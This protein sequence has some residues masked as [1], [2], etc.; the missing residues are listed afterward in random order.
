MR[1]NIK[2][3]IKSAAKTQLTFL[4]A[5]LALVMSSSAFADSAMSSAA[6]PL[7]AQTD[8]QALLKRIEELERKL[9]LLSSNQNGGQSEKQSADQSSVAAQVP[10]TS[11]AESQADLPVAAQA[12]T[13]EKAQ[14][15]VARGSTGIFE[16]GGS[17]FNPEIGVILNGRF[18]SYSQD[19][20]EPSGYAIGHEGERGKEGFSVD[21]TELRLSSNI[22][23]NFYGNVTVALAEHEGE[24]EVELEEAYLETLPDLGLPSG[25]SL[26]A[27][28]ALWQLGYLNAQHSHT[29]DF[30]DRPLLYRLMLDGAYNDDGVQASYLLPTSQYIEVGGGAFAGNDFPFSEADTSSPA[31]LAFVRTGADLSASTSFTAGASYLSGEA[32]ERESNDDE[33]SFTGDSDLAVVDAKLTFS[34]SQNLRYQQLTL[35]GEYFHQVED[36]E[37][38]SETD[39]ADLN[40]KTDGWYAQSIYRFHPEYRVGLRYADM[41]PDGALLGAE[42]DDYSSWSVM[43]DWSPSEFSRLRLQLNRED[44]GSETDNQVVLQYIMSLGAHSAHNY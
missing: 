27:G 17:R 11:L 39:A 4:A 10:N 32:N 42:A 14:P 30:A 29:D 2:P 19:E 40:R 43:G 3:V 8:N 12:A 13:S 21:H 38:A 23:S 15:A 44:I 31:W 26:K 18:A 5:S 22:D 20:S 16:S 37:F 25:L 24:I 35:Q 33:L 34:P 41:N 7:S 6:N 36:G 1:T 28:R 9:L